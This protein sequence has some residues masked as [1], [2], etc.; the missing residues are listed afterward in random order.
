[1][2]DPHIVVR[3]YDHINRSLGNWDTPKGK[4]ITS[5]KHYESELKKQDMVSSE[6]A[7]ELKAKYDQEHKRKDYKPDKETREFYNYVKGTADKNGKVKLGGK[8]LEFMKSKG[9]KFVS[10]TKEFLDK[11][12]GKV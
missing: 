11:A 5:K 12:D 10:P 9:V 8:A 7:Q 6:K 1:M 3:N 2:S 4:R